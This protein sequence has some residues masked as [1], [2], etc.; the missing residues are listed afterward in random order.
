MITNVHERVLDAPPTEIGTLT[1]GLASDDDRLWPSDCWP[2]IRL[3]RPLGSGRREDTDRSA[4][5]SAT[6][7]RGRHV[8]SRFDP[9]LGLVGHH[10]LELATRA[11]RATL[12]HTLE[13]TPP[14]V[15]ACASLGR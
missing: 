10:E 2:P 4:I 7:S 12:R 8:R 14:F 11:G 6:S 3:D 13:A 5:R 1:D 9:W 15:A